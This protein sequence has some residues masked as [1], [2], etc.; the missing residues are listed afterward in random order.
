MERS[1]IGIK[2]YYIFLDPV[3]ASQQ[4]EIPD[5][6]VKLDTCQNSMQIANTFRAHVFHT[7]HPK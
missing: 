4:Q 1:T 6:A 2:D 3:L 7:I 5:N